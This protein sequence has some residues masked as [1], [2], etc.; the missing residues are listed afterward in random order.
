M[1]RGAISEGSWV[2]PRMTMRRFGGPVSVKTYPRHGAKEQ[3]VF[4]LRYCC[5]VKLSSA[6][7]GAGWGLHRQLLQ[8]P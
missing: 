1:H 5:E 6:H 3:S 7:H 2:S 4:E 8:S